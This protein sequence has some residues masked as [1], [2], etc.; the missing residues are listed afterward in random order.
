MFLFQNNNNI[1]V[2]F[3]YIVYSILYDFIMRL[4]YL[5]T[6]QGC[7][8]TV[9]SCTATNDILFGTDNS[10]QK[11][12]EMMFYN[13][14]GKSCGHPLLPYAVPYRSSIFK[15]NEFSSRLQP[16]GLVGGKFWFLGFESLSVYNGPQW[17]RASIPFQAALKA[18]ELWEFSNNLISSIYKKT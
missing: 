1:L 4:V 12:N 16:A 18:E 10:V 8:S 3:L 13:R 15:A 5:S 2:N 6:E 11:L 14:S 9:F 17:G 7:M